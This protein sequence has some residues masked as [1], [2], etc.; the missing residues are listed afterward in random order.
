MIKAKP[1]VKWAGGKGNLLNELEKLPW[2]YYYNHFVKD[3]LYINNKILNKKYEQTY[4]Y[5]DIFYGIC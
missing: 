5:C 2:V 1:F 4:F 3:D